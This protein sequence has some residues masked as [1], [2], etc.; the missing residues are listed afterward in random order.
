MHT[1]QAEHGLSVL[2]AQV[3]PHLAGVLE[4]ITGDGKILLD[5]LR[6]AAQQQCGRIADLVVEFLFGG[7]LQVPVIDQQGL[8][9]RHDL[10]RIGFVRVPAKMARALNPHGAGH[11]LQRSLLGIIHPLLEHRLHGLHVSKQL[12][13]LLAG[14]VG[15]EIASP[16]TLRK[17]QGK[18]GTKENTKH[19][20]TFKYRRRRGFGRDTR[21]VD[22]MKGWRFQAGTADCQRWGPGARTSRWPLVCIS[23][24]TP[25]AS[26]ASIILAARLYPIF[27]LRWTEEMEARR[28][29]S[30]NSTAWSYRGSDSESPPPSPPA[31]PGAGPASWLPSRISSR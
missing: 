26:I 30:T 12:V 2:R 1:Q 11:M 13:E 24:T 15:T 21:N 16:G 6:I 8:A 10:L 19:G 31:S 17:R 18:Q 28:D 29:S 23:V 27:S 3:E 4:H 22:R 9:V 25:A 14:L 7:L 5:L 20:I